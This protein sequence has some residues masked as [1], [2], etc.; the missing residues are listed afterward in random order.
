[1]SALSVCLG[2]IA[3]ISSV[4]LEL[5]WCHDSIDPDFSQL[6]FCYVDVYN[7]SNDQAIDSFEY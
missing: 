3:A 6:W 2:T 4:K 5:L 1:M 7:S